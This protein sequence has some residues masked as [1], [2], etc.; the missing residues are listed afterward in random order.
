MCYQSGDH[1][2]LV[3]QLRAVTREFIDIEALLLETED[4][5]HAPT[6]THHLLCGKGA[7]KNGQPLPVGEQHSFAP[8]GCIHTE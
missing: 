1:K 2:T 8:A 4:L 3:A 6:V 5:L 7:Q